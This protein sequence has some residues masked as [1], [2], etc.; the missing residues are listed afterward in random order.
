M[1]HE[2]TRRIPKRLFV[3]DHHKLLICLVPKTGVTSY[4]SMLIQ[5][6]EHFM[7]TYPNKTAFD[8]FGYDIYNLKNNF[9]IV[10][11]AVLAPQKLYEALTSF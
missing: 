8:E 9:T 10:R 11:A 3:D 1:P 2:I 4:I 7:Y 5:Y 6:S